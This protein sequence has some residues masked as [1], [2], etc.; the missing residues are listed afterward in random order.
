[1]QT[2]VAI[3]ALHRRVA[4]NQRLMAVGAFHLCVPSAQRKFRVP[5]V[6]LQLRTKRFPILRRMTLLALNLERIAVWAANWRI[7][8]DM[9]GERNALGVQ[10]ETE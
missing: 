5:M 4:E 6:E 8:R 7:E 9:L 10:N 2:R 1:M 3:L